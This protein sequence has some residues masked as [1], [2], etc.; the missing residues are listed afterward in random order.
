MTA[1][2]RLCCG[3]RHFGPVCPD[4]HVMCCLCFDRFTIDQLAVDD[5]GARVDVCQACDADERRRP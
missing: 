5:D 2:V 1:P 3:R 4:G